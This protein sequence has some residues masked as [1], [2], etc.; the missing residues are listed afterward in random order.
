MNPCI[1]KLKDLDNCE[2]IAFHN[3]KNM[4]QMVINKTCLFTERIQYLYLKRSTAMRNK[5]IS[6]LEKF[7]K[8]SIL[9]ENFEELKNFSD[10]FRKY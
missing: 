7:A 10:V 8:A 6:K 9:E 2:S 4:I 3:L 5:T 1:E